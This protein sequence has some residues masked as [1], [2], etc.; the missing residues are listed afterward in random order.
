MKV[1]CN[2]DQLL[3]AFQ[4]VSPVVP[5]KSSMPVLQNV[6]LSADDKA[7]FISATDLEVGIQYPLSAEI[8]EK[9][10]IIIPSG[11]LGGILRETTDEQITIEGV[12]G[13]AN[14]KTKTSKY[15]IM[16]M[17]S[18]E[19]PDFPAFNEKKA[20]SI[21]ASGLKEM[22]CKTTFAVS[23][24]ITRYALTGLL[25]EIRKKELRMV[26]SDGKRLAYIKRRSEQEV[27]SDIKVIVSPKALNLLERIIEDEEQ[28]IKIET[29]ETQFKAMIPQKDQKGIILFSRLI[30]GAFPDYESVIPP[31]SDKKIEMPAGELLSAMKRVSLVTTDK[32]KATQIS[33]E[34]DKMTLLTRTQDVGEATVELPIKYS[35]EAFRIT[36]NPE[37]F[38]DMLRIVGDE[39][40]TLGL[41]DKTSPAVIK[42]GKDYV[43]IVMPLTIEM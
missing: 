12:G 4:V 39:N 19:Y 36:F 20:I 3:K 18:A 37:F 21:S 34:K 29:D 43:Y 17:D 30:E 23:Q 13:A 22:V 15:K 10:T 24:E 25:M 26:A 31:D 6:K 35:S 27:A 41:K 2:K 16:C 42:Q 38:I 40:I 32:F 11:R 7:L 33:M 28:V 5:A 8:K 9:G 14:I 1:I